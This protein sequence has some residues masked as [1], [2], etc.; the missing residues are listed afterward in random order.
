MKQLSG[1]LYLRAYRT[2]DE[3]PSKVYS[4]LWELRLHGT[5]QTSRT[6]HLYPPRQSYPVS[7]LAKPL[8]VQNSI[9]VNDEFPHRQ[10]LPRLLIR[11]RP[12]RRQK[13]LMFKRRVVLKTL[14]NRISRKLTINFYR[15]GS[16]RDKK[17]GTF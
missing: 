17:R 12:Q 1:H 8:Y 3:S 9:G 10:F 14:Q 4:R 5:A 6:Q 11:R 13:I 15:A 2:C 7:I 16:P